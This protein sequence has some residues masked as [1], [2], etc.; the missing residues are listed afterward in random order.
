ML[1][2]RCE[3]SYN[4][5]ASRKLHSH[6]SCKAQ[7]THVHWTHKYH[8]AKFFFF[9]SKSH[10]WIK[11]S[12]SHF[13]SL[14]VSFVH[15]DLIFFF[16]FDVKLVF[17]LLLLLP[18]LLLLLLQSNVNCEANPKCMP[19]ES[20]ISAGIGRNSPKGAKHPKIGQILI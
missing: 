5:E 13:I 6:Q 10:K 9:F 19:I 3:C 17:L 4:Y 8:I 7:T 20:L 1:N 16:L 2:T 14:E 18:L 15:N 11:V 12:H